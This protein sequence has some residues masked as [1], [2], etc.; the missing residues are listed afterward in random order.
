MAIEEAPVTI[1]NGGTDAETAAALARQVA[2]SG[3]S[4]LPT[5]THHASPVAEI[6]YG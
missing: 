3:E 5:N 1:S 4:Q 2:A 6:A